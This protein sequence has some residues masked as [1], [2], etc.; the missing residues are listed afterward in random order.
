MA[1]DCKDE[2]EEPSNGERAREGPKKSVRDR[3]IVR[4]R[5]RGTD[6]ER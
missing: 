1:R 4:E 6:K 2:R 5:A 3:V